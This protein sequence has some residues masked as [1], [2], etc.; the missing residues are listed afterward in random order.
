[1]KTEA[2]SE[3]VLAKISSQLAAIE[4][5]D[6]ELWLIVAVTGTL[7][8]VGLLAITF[9]AAFMDGKNFQMQIDVPKELF[10]GLLVLLILFNIYVI[11]RR[12]ELRKTRSALI[13]TTIQGELTR[14]QSF[15]DPLT[16]V[17]NRRSLHDMADRYLSR[18]K[19]LAKPLSFMIADADRF[20]EVNTRFGHLTGDFVIA[21][22]AS[23]LRGAVRG[24]DAV[25]RYGG[26]EFLI[27]LADAPIEGGQVV[28]LRIA[29]FVDEWNRAG[30]LPGFELSLSVGLAEWSE[31]KSLDQVMN[32]ADQKMYSTKE[33]QKKRG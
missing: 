23:L 10:L 33:A 7:V 3:S 6:W 24:S 19:R 27:I 5:R 15:M 28:A 11:T 22:L 8:A 18:A 13:S 4:K 20:K 29:K 26:D 14:L 1:M 9:P 31:E 32:E 30:H 16:E 25:I 21:E 2:Q 12:L 17:Y